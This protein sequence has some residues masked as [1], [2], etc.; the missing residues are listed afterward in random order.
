M[1]FDVTINATLEVDDED[2][3]H[4]VDSYDEYEG[5]TIEELY[6]AEVFKEDREATR[7]EARIEAM[8]ELAS[9]LESS[10]LDTIYGECWVCSAD[11]EEM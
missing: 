10:N 9:D 7:A 4:L 8:N 2:F 5:M 6:E 1:Q 11:V 3:E